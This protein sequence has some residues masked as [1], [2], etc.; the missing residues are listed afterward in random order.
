M[1]RFHAAAMLCAVSI[2]AAA[3][4]QDSDDIIV[5]AN[6]TATPI[7]KVGL[8][9]SVIDADD[10]A[11]LQTPSVSE[12]LRM[13][14]GMAITRNGGMGTFSSVLVRGASSE[15]TVALIDG[16]KI[17]DPSSPAGGFDFGRLM[18][19]NLERIEVVRGPQSVL[20]GSQAIGGV[21]NIITRQPAERPSGN[22]QAEYGYRD[23]VDLVGN[24][25]ATLGPVALSA[26]ASYARTDGISAFSEQRGG[27]ERDGTE[28]YGANVNAR[29]TITDNLSLDLRG[30]Y[31]HSDTDLDGF[32]PPTYAFGDTRGRNR[33]R[34]AIGYAGVNWNGL[35]GRWRNRMAYSIT[36]VRRDDYDPDALVEHQNDAFG[37]N[38][39]AEFQSTF[40][41]M[42]GWTLVTGAEREWSTFTIASDYGYGATTIGGKNRITSFYGQ[43]MASPFAGLTTTV[44]LRHDDHSRFGGHMSFA[45]NAAYTPN[46]GATI[47]R[48]SYGEGF[49]APSLYQLFSEY[50][51][52][53]L[54]P[55]T[56][57]NWDVGIV[58]KALDDAVQVGVTWFR[59]KTRNLIDYV[60]CAG[61]GDPSPLCD[62]AFDG[63]YDN[64]DR[65][66]A[67]G[68]EAEIRLKPVEALLVNFNYSY[69]KSQDLTTDRD[70]ARRPRHK[71]YAAIDY[72]W[73][74]GLSTGASITH[75]SASYDSASGANR[76]A[77]YV[78]T[79]IRASYPVTDR[80]EVYGRIDNLFDQ[81]YE[82]VYGYG[83]L[84]RAAYA[85]IRFRL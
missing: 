38:Q 39:R 13:V 64:V 68:L 6:R 24:G 36:S 83:S 78:L 84:G 43:L 35:D 76:N 23:T 14:P 5:T 61:A 27:R 9:V 12:L 70:L 42:S 59:R 28:Q 49:K 81:G 26:G 29:T 46:D 1:T 71:A 19:G 31:S 74:F 82:S 69:V 56:A 53:A 54:K 47:L 30:W 62:Y 7:S 32:P 44:G 80:V 51:N 34:E 2:P 48:A 41:I 60:S 65:A 58:Q 52:G 63:Y 85:G 22:V 17:N 72:R 57:K 3:W 25:A 37:R 40:D 15:H 50:G 73:P 33:T 11:R 10:I 66:L 45:A 18:S 8:S 20:W 55:E 21:V 4:A 16:V 75:V 79:D 67:K 77:D